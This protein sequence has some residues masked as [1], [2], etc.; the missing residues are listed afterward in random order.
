MTPEGARTWRF[1]PPWWAWLLAALG[2]ALGIALGQWQAGRAAEK[3]AAAREAAVEVE[4]RGELL[5]AHTMYL[6]NRIHEG[7]PGYLVLQP[8]RL[9]QGE[10][11]LVL[12]GWIGPGADLHKPSAFRTPEGVLVL[13]GARLARLARALEPPGAARTGAVR[14]NASLEEFAAWSGL[15]LAPYVLQ[16][17]AGPDDGLRRDWPAPDAGAAKNDSYALQWYALALLSVLLFLV[18]N[19][20]RESAFP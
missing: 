3:R 9:P 5:A 10:H 1:R 13:K 15:T 12:R 8:L 16:Q 11:V 20:R 4:L 6:A 17:R 7:R 2:C 19:V 14:Q 18:L